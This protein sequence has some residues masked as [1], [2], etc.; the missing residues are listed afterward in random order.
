MLQ[1]MHGKAKASSIL[2]RFVAKLTMLYDQ[3]DE[4]GVIL[5]RML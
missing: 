3:S 2:N 4:N 1:N 5:C